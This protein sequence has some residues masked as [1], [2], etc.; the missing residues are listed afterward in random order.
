[1]DYCNNLLTSHISFGGFRTFRFFYSFDKKSVKNKYIKFRSLYG[2]AASKIKGAVFIIKTAPFVITML[3]K[4][5][6]I[7]VGYRK[8]YLHIVSGSIRIRADLVCLFR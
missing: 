8:F 3:K 5:G 2:S 7:V 6:L 4:I 1:M